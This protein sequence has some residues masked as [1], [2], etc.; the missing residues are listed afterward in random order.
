ML[1]LLLCSLSAQAAQTVRVGGYVFPP[2]V[3]L[4]ADQ[5][6]GLTLELLELLNEVQQDYRFE[7][8][9]TSPIRRFR[10]FEAGRFEVIFFESP[11]WGW[12]AR[13]I[14]HQA[15]AVFLD[16]AEVYIA[17]RAPGRGQE[18]FD[19]PQSRRI[20]AIL[21]YH[22]GFA[23]FDGDPEQLRQRFDI[24]LVNSNTASI[25]LVLR[26]RAELAA[27]TRS[28]LNRYLGQHPEA[29][30]KLLVSERS[31][32]DYRHQVLLRP[33]SALTAGA[34]DVLLAQL[35]ASGKASPLWQRAGLAP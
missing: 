17:R 7:F 29:R 4:K 27:V 15:S 5:P 26:Q 32:Q 28:Y 3:E 23:D 31:D 13:G 33:D 21:G 30:D 6:V 16:D 19:A 8:V 11:A 14:A 12:N 2:Y 24:I 9:L 20:A 25:E 1:L 22:Y 10:D 34:I 18:F 35:E